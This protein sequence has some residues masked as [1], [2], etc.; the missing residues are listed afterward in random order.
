MKSQLSL[1]LLASLYDSSYAYTILG[2]ID[3]NK[4]EGKKEDES[5][6]TEH[7]RHLN[8]KVELRTQS[9]E[10]SGRVSMAGT[11]WEASPVLTHYI[12]NPACPVEGF[13]RMLPKEDTT[14]PQR[15]SSVV[16]LGSG[17]GLVSLSAAF[18]G[19]QVVATDGSPSSIR[20][21]EENFDRYR[22]D[23]K[24]MPR[25]SL[26]DWG[27]MVAAEQL[28]QHD[29]FG[30]YPDVIVASDVI[31]AHSAK[32]EL[33]NTIKYL[34]PVGHDGCILI[35]HRWRTEPEEEM[36][37]FESFDTEFDRE[38]VGVEWLPEDSYFRTKS[39]IDFKHP[40]S[41]YQMRRKS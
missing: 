16:E 14:V 5:L 17:V 11:L 34:C 1:L 24:Y 33:A 19:C 41:I 39:M 15:P 7:L 12:T 38:E 9:H 30:Q 8:R 18:L 40:V 26:L 37:F 22:H 31:Y 23:F 36:A 35:A 32:I 27:D 6:I 2:G 10:A 28:I 20:L 3:D 13:Q 29:L 4:D 25:A 21:L